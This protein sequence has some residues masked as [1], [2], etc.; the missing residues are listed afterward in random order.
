MATRAWAGGGT[1]DGMSDPIEII[2]AEALGKV[3]GQWEPQWGTVGAFWLHWL[4]LDRVQVW[5]DGLPDAQERADTG[6]L[7][8][9]ARVL[10]ASGDMRA[11]VEVLTRVLAVLKPPDAKLPS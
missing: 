4:D 5:V 3:H 6:A 2:E 8:E 7:M 10:R 11:E 9:Q 1:I